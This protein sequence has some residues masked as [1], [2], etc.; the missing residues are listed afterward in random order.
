[1]SGLT[2]GWYQETCVALDGVSGDRLW[3][4]LLDD[5]EGANSTP[6][7]VDGRVYVYSG[8]CK[9]YCLD[10]ASGRVQ[11]KRDLAREFRAGSVDF[12]NSQSPW[13][14]DGRIFVSIVA[15]TNCLMAF[16]ASNG[17]L[18]WQGHTNALTY[19]SPV[20]ATLH[21]IRQ[22]IF[23]DRYGLVSVDPDTGRI[24]WRHRQGDSIR[25]GPSPVV[26]GE[27]V[28]CAKSYD[29][30][31]TQAVRIGCSNGVFSTR[32]LW[33]N[34]FSA[35]LY[36]T[37]VVS[38]EHVYMSSGSGTGNLKCVELTSG[39]V[40]WE[41]GVARFSSVI[42]VDRHLLALAG[43]GRLFL[44]QASPLGYREMARSP[45]RPYGDRLM[46]LNSLAFSNGRIYARDSYELVGY[47]AVPP[48]LNV[49]ARLLPV[50]DQLQ[51]TVACG[52]GS[53]L[54]S[55]RAERIRI[56]WAS[57]PGQPLAQ[58]T[59][60]TM[61]A[62]YTNGLLRSEVPLSGNGPPRFYVAAE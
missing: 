36:T 40:K 41:S 51:L 13:V 33:T 50:T 37:M 8:E 1:M 30:S 47:T 49:S 42:L 6:T 21:G 61:P 11:W 44:I 45:I 29:S 15:P 39:K 16:D 62:I 60:I 3:S 56:W 31:G 43:D 46:Y 53:A 17:A 26:H 57:D 58:W 27:I 5:A 28:L 12:G 7:V 2:N 35:D 10:A 32:V 4:T 59:P 20:G 52:D 24:L 22:I 14:E 9:L 38:E 54:S 34:R 19:A 48:P 25:Q 18:L 55:K 23:P